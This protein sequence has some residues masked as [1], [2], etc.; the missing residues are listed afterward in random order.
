MGVSDG[1]NTGK[2]SGFWHTNPIVP[3]FSSVNL[4]SGG[5][6]ARVFLTQIQVS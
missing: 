3:P 4:F 5:S 6:M 1:I 2:D